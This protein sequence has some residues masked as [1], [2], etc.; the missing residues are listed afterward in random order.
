MP[1]NGQLKA[2]EPCKEKEVVKDREVSQ[3]AALLFLVFRR[4]QM[5]VIAHTYTLPNGPRQM[6]SGLRLSH[7]GSVRRRHARGCYC[8]AEAADSVLRTMSENGEVAVLVVEGTELVQEVGCN[9]SVTFLRRSL[10]PRPLSEACL[11]Q[12]RLSPLLLSA[13]ASFSCGQD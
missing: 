9:D 4:G 7:A 2:N 5:V 11:A 3:T 13:P 12:R 8:R 1:I 10:R 6:G